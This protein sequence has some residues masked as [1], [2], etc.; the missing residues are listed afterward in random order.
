[1]SSTAGKKRFMYKKIFPADL[2]HLHKMLNFIEM[3][4][5]EKKIPPVTLNKIVLAVEEVLVNIIYYGYPDRPGTIEIICEHLSGR[6]AGMC[7]L[8]KDQG[9]PFNPIEKIFND[10][11][12]LPYEIKMG[13]YGIYLFIGI[14]DKVEYKRQHEGNV[15]SL[16]KYFDLS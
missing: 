3:K 10:R 8:I 14:M 2:D 9:I 12:D 6:Q 4:G 1:M 13:G 11:S 7:I 15:L 5:K 16:I